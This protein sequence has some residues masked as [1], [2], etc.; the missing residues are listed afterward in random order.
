MHR[1]SQGPACRISHLDR[2]PLT[3]LSNLVA[4]D[5]DVVNV[6]AQRHVVP[7][8]LEEIP[9]RPGGG[10]ANL[11]EDDPGSFLARNR[12]DWLTPTL[13]EHRGYRLTL[14]LGG[15]VAITTPHLLAGVADD[16]INNPLIDP[17]RG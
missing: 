3:C 16:V 14:E 11:L 10:V 7:G 4:P 13:T 17:R 1:A 8:G 15:Q 2:L 5:R 6:P 9:G 12:G